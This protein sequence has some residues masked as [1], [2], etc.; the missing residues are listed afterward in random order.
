MGSANIGAT[1][2]NRTGLLREDTD[3][4]ALGGRTENL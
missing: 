4:L 3:I 2:R 1:A